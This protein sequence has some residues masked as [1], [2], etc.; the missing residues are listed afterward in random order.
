MMFIAIFVIRNI[1][2]SL[3]KTK[4]FNSKLLKKQTIQIR[5]KASLFTRWS[6]QP[7]RNEMKIRGAI[8]KTPKMKIQRKTLYKIVLSDLL[9]YSMF[10]C[11]IN[12]NLFC[13][14]LKEKTSFFLFLYR[15]TRKETVFVVWWQKRRKKKN[16]NKLFHL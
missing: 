10:I 16:K 12:Y 11:S 15:V 5:K 3:T 6:K 7:K 8:N 14:F 4:K 13:Q 1:F 9:Q 2:D